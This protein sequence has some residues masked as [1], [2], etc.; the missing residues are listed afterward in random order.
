[1]SQFKNPEIITGVRKQKNKMINLM[2]GLDTG[3]RKQKRNW[4]VWCPAINTGVRK[5]KTNLIKLMSGV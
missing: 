2:S 4:L 5:Q 1:M 3:V